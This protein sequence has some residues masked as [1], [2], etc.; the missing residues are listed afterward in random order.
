LAPSAV[1]EPWI[2]NFAIVLLL[3]VPCSPRTNATTR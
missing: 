1:Y 3:G 2:R